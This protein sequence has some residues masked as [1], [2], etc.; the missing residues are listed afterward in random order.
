MKLREMRRTYDL[1]P[2]EFHSGF[3]GSPFPGNKVFSSLVMR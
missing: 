1:R 3:A 2:N